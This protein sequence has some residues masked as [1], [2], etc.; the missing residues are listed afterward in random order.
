MLLSPRQGITGEVVLPG[1]KSISNRVLLLAALAKGTTRIKRLLR[2]DDTEVMIRALK[3]LGMNIEENDPDQ[4]LTVHGSAGVF[5]NTGSQTNP[6]KLFVGNSGLT[7]RTLLPA[8][9]ASMAKTGGCAEISGVA[10]MHERPIKDLVEGLR[11]I[12]AKI[13]YL[14]KPGFPP[15][16]IEG[17]PL[18]PKTEISVRG[19]TSSQYLTGLL[20]AA[21]IIAKHWG[22]A[23]KIEVEGELISQPYIEI[24]CAVLQKLGVKVKRETSPKLAYQIEPTDISSPGELAVEGDASSASY[25]LAAGAIG[26]GPV[27][28]VG[29]GQESIQGD[30]QFAHALEKMGACIE[31]GPDWIESSWDKPAS[32]PHAMDGDMVH[33]M[34]HHLKGVDLD[35][36]AIPDAAMTL[37]VCALFASNPT[38]LRNIGSWRVKE[39][40]RIAAVAAEC[41]QL[42]ARVETGDDWIRIHP[43][44]SLKPAAIQT[45]D[46]HR[47]AMSFSLAAF[48]NAAIR[49]DDPGC[50]AKTY[51]EYFEVLSSLCAQAVPV[52][53]ID[54][55]TASGK[56]TVASLV[57]AELGFGYLDSGALY[58]LT[59]L[60]ARQAAVSA[61]DEQ[62]LASIATEVDL[63]FLGQTILLDGVNVSAAIR[64]EEIGLAASR[65]AVHPAVR[66]ALLLRQRDFARLPGLV[67][68]GR[69]MGTVVF[70]QARLK[71]FLT[72]TPRARA[73]RRYKQLIDNGFSA[74]LDGLSADLEA[75][76]AR[77]ASRAV[78]PLKPASG[79]VVIDSTILSIDEV[80]QAVVNAWHQVSVKQT[81]QLT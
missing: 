30:I 67:A 28:V 24:T 37:A 14:G 12:G 10:R 49:I 42:G 56:G 15:L 63:E 45:Y 77:D 64:Q 59:A 52:L 73:E 58:R 79:A 53:A 16:R 3:G 34:P 60:A 22:Q 71:V 70:P 57:A 11:A 39:T 62:A 51:P 41:G 76:D 1:S 72:A 33:A 46:D 4:T 36:N 44:E 23:V 50:V 68:D 75:R 31:W 54:G 80:V 8:L 43:P 6:V 27:R 18:L 25:F 40:D 2:S 66:G 7:I 21:P 55:P 69:D 9:V 35:C 5:A 47:M 13:E 29:V 74:N 26:H 78:A 38:T 20:Q 48:G 65:V 81:G 61:E 32:A 17:V 19:D